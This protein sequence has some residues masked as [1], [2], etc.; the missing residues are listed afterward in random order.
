MLDTNAI[1]QQLKPDLKVQIEALLEGGAFRLKEIFYDPL[2]TG[3]LKKDIELD[4]NERIQPL[5]LKYLANT[6]EAQLLS[7][8]ISQHGIDC[9]RIGMLPHNESGD[10]YPL[11]ID[12]LIDRAGAGDRGL[13]VNDFKNLILIYRPYHDLKTRFTNA[14]TEG[15]TKPTEILALAPVT[16]AGQETNIA[17]PPGTILEVE[18]LGR[19]VWLYR[20]KATSSRYLKALERLAGEPT[21]SSSYASLQMEV[22]DAAEA[23]RKIWEWAA[24]AHRAAD[25]GG[26]NGLLMG[27][28][29]VTAQKETKNFFKELARQDANISTTPDVKGPSI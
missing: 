9:M 6:Q 5:F 28:E 11:N 4:F 16:T 27:N 3:Q 18:R 21:D 20:A 22:R 1:L 14:Q 7:I 24:A 2:T 12:H 26:Y 15:L 13:E 25:P 19:P 23:K 17:V 8:G 29:S 10:P